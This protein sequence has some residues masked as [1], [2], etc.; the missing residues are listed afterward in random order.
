MAK[1]PGPAQPAKVDPGRQ[2]LVEPI[3]PPP[4]QLGCR[5]V[6]IA[7]VSEADHED[8]RTIAVTP[9]AAWS[10]IPQTSYQ[11]I[12]A[13]PKVTIANEKKEIDVPAGANLRVEL[14]KAGVQ[15]YSGLARWINCFGHGSCGT[16]RVL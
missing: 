10:L 12:V 11:R 7:E 1:S 6:N 4:F 14:R 15:V 9:R 13:M 3:P 2:A 16:C 5:E 8:F